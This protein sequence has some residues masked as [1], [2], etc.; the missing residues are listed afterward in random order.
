MSDILAQAALEAAVPTKPNDKKKPPLMGPVRTQLEAFGTAILAAVLMK[1]FC[2]EAFQIPTSS[3]Q[4]TLMGGA[5]VNDRIVVNK[6]LQLVREPQRWDIT[7]FSYPLQ[8]NQNYVKRIVGMPNDRLTIAGGDVWQ[9]TDVDGKRS[10]EVLRKPADLQEAM[11]KNVHPLRQQV[12]AEKSALGSSLGGSPSRLFREDGTGIVVDLDGQLAELSYRDDTDGGM[13]DRVWDGYPEAVARVMR[14]EAVAGPGL[15]G[16]PQEIVADVRIRAAVTPPPGLDELTFEIKVARPNEDALGYALAWRAGKATLVVRKK[17]NIA[18]QSPEF[19]LELPAGTATELGFAHIDDELV[20][21]RNGDELARF[22]SSQWSCRDGCMLPFVPGMGPGKGLE[23]P[24]NQKVTPLIIAKGK[25]PLRLDDLRI[26]RDQHYTRLGA[27]EVIEIPD[28]HYYMLG[29][30]TLQSIDSR[31]WT[32]IT[33][34]VDADDNVVPPETPG[35]R[36]VRGNKRAMDLSGPPDRDETPI[37]YPNQKAIVMIDE[38]GE[39][40]RLHADIAGNW[41]RRIAFQRPG[42]TDASGE[43]TAAETTNSKGI[44]FVPRSD[45]RGRA[46]LIFYPFRP[47]AW[48][49]GNNW[50]G[51]FGFV[52]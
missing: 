4:P 24:A 38:Y 48:L 52:R 49:T 51:R 45:I 30:N 20:A 7:V 15:A 18:G 23:L 25:G 46:T 36:T 32:A 44:S 29:D 41:G 3:M 14:D 43:W 27:P 10:Y 13:I 11:W 33:I 34:G 9:V 6:M 31:G 17:G 21:W 8:K 47:L 28:G 37:A 35:A 2:I 12:R 19:A 40:L 1:W 39:I 22:P 50:P 16:T 26:D 5:G 42:T